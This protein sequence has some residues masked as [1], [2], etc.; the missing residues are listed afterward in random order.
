MNLEQIA[1]RR[2]DI[3]AR[4]GLIARDRAKLSRE[5]EDAAFN[6]NKAAAEDIANRSLRIAHLDTEAEG[7][8]DELVKLEGKEKTAREKA[9]ALAA[10]RHAA[11]VPK[12]LEAVAAKREADARLIQALD[13]LQA[14]LGDRTAAV[15]AIRGAFPT[16]TA[17]VALGRAETPRLI[18]QHLRHAGI[19]QAVIGH[20]PSEKP[21]PYAEAAEGVNG[22]IEAAAR[23]LGGRADAA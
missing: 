23:E 14:A 18:L 3:G 13:A 10:E 21:T 6:P 1:A 20:I 5:N 2:A 12:V 8:R 11:A 7:L 19:A 16:G 9:D 15:Q 17:P 4:L 22:V